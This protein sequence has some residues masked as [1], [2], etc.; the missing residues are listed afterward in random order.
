MRQFR[1]VQEQVGR[2]LAWL[3]DLELALQ[4]ESVRCRW[5]F[6]NNLQY[7]AQERSNVQAQEA[8]TLIKLST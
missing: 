7:D 3:G 5:E 8:E 6:D 2:L 4:G 1:S